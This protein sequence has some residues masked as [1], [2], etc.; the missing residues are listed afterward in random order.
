MFTCF[1]TQTIIAADVYDEC[2]KILNR[3]YPSPHYFLL[4]K[5]KDIFG[6]LYYKAPKNVEPSR[7]HALLDE[8]EGFVF[9]ATLIY[10]DKRAQKVLIFYQPFDDCFY[11]V[12]A[13]NFKVKPLVR[14]FSR[15][16]VFRTFTFRN[17]NG[18]PEYLIYR[19][20]RHSITFI[21]YDHFPPEWV[22]LVTDV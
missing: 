7:M 2:R 12:D 19:I 5:D 18:K 22:H 20:F 16:R 13:K 4:P 11:C 14:R 15:Q 1:R 9:R 10:T 8:K 17:E 6:R 21:V 3:D